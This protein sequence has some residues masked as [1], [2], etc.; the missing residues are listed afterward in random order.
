MKGGGGGGVQI[1]PPPQKKL[2]SKSPTLLGLKT[3]RTIMQA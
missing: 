3:T 1:H 2:P